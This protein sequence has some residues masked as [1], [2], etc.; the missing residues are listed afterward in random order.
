MLNVY[1]LV[2]AT[3]L[4]TAAVHLY[5]KYDMLIMMMFKP[6]IMYAYTAVNGKYFSGHACMYPRSSACMNE[7]TCCWFACQHKLSV[8]VVCVCWHYCGNKITSQTH[9]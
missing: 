4:V 9:P 6:T 8:A 7:F 2:P 1:L 3:Q 5:L